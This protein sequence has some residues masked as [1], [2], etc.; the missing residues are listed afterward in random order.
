MRFVNKLSYS[1]AQ[2]LAAAMNENHQKR[3]VY[4]F[5]FQII[6]G[7]VIKNIVLLSLAILLGVLLPALVSAAV[8]AAIRMLAGGYHMD[9][10]GKCL[11]VSIFMFMLAALTAQYTYQYWNYTSLAVL[12][13]ITL[14]YGLYTMIR[15]APKDT[16]HKPITDSREIKKFKVL[17]ILCLVVLIISASILA[18][19][20]LNIFALAICFGSILELFTVTPLGNNFFD[21]IRNGIA[22]KREKA[23]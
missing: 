10:Y 3:S 17:S 14:V 19:F 23:A 21:M 9:T 11:L 2:K 5:S 8:F 15:Y 22:H 16:P 18:Y 4:Y 1:C 20:N 6:F 7:G 12:I 13:A